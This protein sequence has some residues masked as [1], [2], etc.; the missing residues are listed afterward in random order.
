MALAPVSD[1]A[2][3]LVGQLRH[4]LVGTTTGVVVVPTGGMERAALERFH[5][6]DHRQLHQVEDPD[7]HHQI[8]SADL[9]APIGSDHP[10]RGALVPLARLHTGV[11]QR[12]IGEIEPAGDRLEVFAD[13]VTEGVARLRDVTRLLEH[14]HVAVRLD[15]AHHARVAVPVPG[16]ADTARVVDH[17]DAIHARLAQLGTGHHARQARA[18]D[19]DIDVLDHRITSGHGRERVRA[20]LREHLVAS[21]VP[22]RGAACHEPLVTLRLILRPDRFR[23]KPSL[24]AVHIPHPEKTDH[25]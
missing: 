23:I 24:I 12:G 9:V 19:R 13:L 15:V 4:G 20:V 22:D 25:R 6:R 18:D 21:Q 5:P 14:R 10:P 8:P 1:D 2:D 7:R 11:E 16:S 17:A 3:D